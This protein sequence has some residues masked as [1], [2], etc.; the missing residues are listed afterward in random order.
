MSA[1]WAAADACPFFLGFVWLQHWRALARDFKSKRSSQKIE[2]YG[3]RYHKAKHTY[4]WSA[5]SRGRKMHPP[6][7]HLHQ[8][9]DKTVSFNKVLMGLSLVVQLARHSCVGR[10]RKFE[11]LFNKLKEKV[12]NRIEYA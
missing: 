4:P 8:F 3:G 11:S 12:A 9:D 1:K 5:K 7:F 2:P 6:A 10:V